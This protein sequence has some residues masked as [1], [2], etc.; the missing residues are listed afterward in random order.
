[1]PDAAAPSTNSNTYW[2]VPPIFETKNAETPDRA[3]LSFP[4]SLLLARQVDSRRLESQ[5][6]R[7]LENSV[8][9]PAKR[10]A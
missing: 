8:L 3:N 4:R 5:G 2:V 7:L 10:P 9:P 1:M 6:Q